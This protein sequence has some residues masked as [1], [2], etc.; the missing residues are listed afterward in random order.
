MRIVHTN[1]MVAVA[2]T[3][4]VGA[5]GCGSSESE[6]NSQDS[7]R[8]PAATSTSAPTTTPQAS[9]SASVTRLA[10]ARRAV[11]AAEHK[12]RGSG[13]YD[14]ES[15]RLRGRRVWEVKVARGTSSPYELDVSADGRKVVRQR[16]RAKISDDVRK[17]A[18]AKVSLHNAL[19]T[20]GSR[21]KSGRFDEAEIDRSRGRVVWEATFKRS[22][23]RE[24]EVRI[25][26]RNGKVIAVEVDD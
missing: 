2:C 14:V 22:G 26:A 7:A 24:V 25:D 5:A 17:L 3:A 15:G 12:V 8:S 13:A 23:D 6:R 19:K 18:R 4:L 9:S 20:A 11:R 16:R 1:A 21:A 10:E